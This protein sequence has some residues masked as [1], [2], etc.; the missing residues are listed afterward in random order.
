MVHAPAVSC[1]HFSD[2]CCARCCSFDLFC[3]RRASVSSSSSC[4]ACSARRSAASLAAAAA[5]LSRAAAATLSSAA[6]K[7]CERRSS[8]VVPM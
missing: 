7:A 2:A 1:L 8:P 3:A 6:C 4:A 5:C